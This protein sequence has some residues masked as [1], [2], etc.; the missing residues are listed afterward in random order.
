M[1]WQLHAYE[2]LS[3]QKCSSSPFLVNLRTFIKE[4]SRLSH[5]HHDSRNYTGIHNFDLHR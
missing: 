1:D 2:L 3:N 5:E 4:N